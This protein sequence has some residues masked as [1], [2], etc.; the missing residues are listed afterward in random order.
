MEEE[1]EENDWARKGIENGLLVD[2]TRL[3]ASKRRYIYYC[4]GKFNSLEW[5]LLSFLTFPHHAMIAFDLWVIGWD[6][7]KQFET[8]RLI[9]WVSF[10]TV[11]LRG[12]FTSSSRFDIK[13][14]ILCNIKAIRLEWHES[15]EF[16]NIVGQFDIDNT[17]W[18][19]YET[20][21]WTNHRWPC[22]Q[23]GRGHEA[24]GIIS[25]TCPLAH[26]TVPFWVEKIDILTALIQLQWRWNVEVQVK[27]KLTNGSLR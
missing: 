5:F 26:I 11:H 25:T 2:R 1:R 6:A 4:D 17:F 9:Q 27:W 24:L 16:P 22:M 18:W 23:F 12:V 10:E 19:L 7:A 20:K 15:T 8:T 21:T 3:N 13:T 14:N